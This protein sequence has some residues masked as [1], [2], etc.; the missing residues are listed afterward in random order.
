VSVNFGKTFIVGFEGEELTPEISDKLKA[1][2]PAGVIL[3]DTNLK[4]AQKVKKL[5]QDLKD[6]LGKDLFI[7]VDQEGGK[8]QRLR[9]VSFELPSLLSIGK[10]SRKSTNEN[11]FLFS[12]EILISYAQALAFQLEELGF[13]FVYGPCADLNLEK[14]NPIIGSRSLGDDYRIVSE[15]L[16]V[17]IEELKNC[18]IYTCAKHF[19]GHGD[20][21]KDS[22]KELPIVTRSLAS[23]L[24][25]LKPFIAAIE[26]GVDSIMIA[27][28][29]LEIEQSN[30]LDTHF[31]DE[32]DISKEELKKLRIV[33]QVKNLPASINKELISKELVYL[34]GFKGLIVS[35]EITMKA[36]SEFGNYTELTKKLLEAGNNL[37]IWNSNLEQALEA[38]KKL[39]SLDPN[40]YS[41]LYDSYQK[42]IDKIEATKKHTRTKK[43]K[44]FSYDEDFFVNSILKSFEAEAKPDFKKIDYI[45]INNHPKLEKDKIEAVF[46]LPVELIQRDLKHQSRRNYIAILFQASIDELFILESIKNQ[47]KVFQVSC[48]T[49]D[50]GSHMNILGAA[51]LHY[52]A[53]NK[54]LFS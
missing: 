34:L 53:L 5:N 7:T 19:P 18:G 35:D 27:H 44:D 14:T 17:I 13:N 25:N 47:N 37:V 45:L 43:Q 1:I 50:P 41:D 33:E 15:Q 48:D 39:N 23:E 2:D 38:A 26:A 8:V 52:K 46:R 51:Q 28:L 20:S 22:H 10:A 21:K 24:I 31:I 16:K 49:H 9:N 32:S 54:Y 6:L 11:S 36:L 12:R 40:L 30:Q 4:D 3:F 29:L 42:S